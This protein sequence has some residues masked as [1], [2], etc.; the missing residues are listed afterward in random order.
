MKKAEIKMLPK[1][2]Q[3]KEWLKQFRTVCNWKRSL[4][5]ELEELG[6]SFHTPK[7]TD[8][9]IKD[10]NNLLAKT[11]LELN[12]ERKLS[13]NRLTSLRQ[14]RERTKT[15]DYPCLENKTFEELEVLRSKE[16]PASRLSKMIDRRMDE[17]A[18][19]KIV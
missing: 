3:K 10:L 12:S 18:Y 9:I 11:L 7:E 1:E 4:E 8:P 5:E 17:I 14:C 16:D 19:Q 15:P 6:V 2:A 13:K